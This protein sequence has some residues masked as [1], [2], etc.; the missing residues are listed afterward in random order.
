MWLSGVKAGWQSEMVTGGY[1]GL[2]WGNV[3]FHVNMLFAYCLNEIVYVYKLFYFLSVTS[4]NDNEA[5][6]LLTIVY[7]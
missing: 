6:L 1:W 2:I 3:I 5:C 7:I 4:A